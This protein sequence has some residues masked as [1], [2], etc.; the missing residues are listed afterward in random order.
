FD[1]LGFLALRIETRSDLGEGIVSLF[2]FVVFTVAAEFGSHGPVCLPMEA[3]ARVWGAVKISGRNSRVRVLP[4]RRLRRNHDGKKRHPIFFATDSVR[5]LVI[6]PAH[7][8]I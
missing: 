6:L 3:R 4:D 8:A 7:S 1:C 2:V 5:S